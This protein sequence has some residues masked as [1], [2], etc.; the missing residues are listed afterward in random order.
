MYDHIFTINADKYTPTDEEFIVT[1]KTELT[2]IFCTG[3]LRER[4]TTT[5]LFL[6]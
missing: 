2:I 1:G 5:I 4:V 6:F 3:I